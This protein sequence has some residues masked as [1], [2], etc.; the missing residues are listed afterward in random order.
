M[1]KPESVGSGS[2]I[3]APTHH[4]CDSLKAYQGTY[5]ELHTLTPPTSYI[6]HSTDYKKQKN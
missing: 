2:S 5:C 6:V 1:Y 3:M 4:P